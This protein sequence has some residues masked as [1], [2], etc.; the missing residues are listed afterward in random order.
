MNRLKSYF[1]EAEEP[2]EPSTAE[3]YYLVE[4]SQYWFAVSSE[5][6]QWIERQL[7]R[8][9]GPR[10]LAFT[11]LWGARRRV[12]RSDVD[13]ISESTPAVRAA[14]RAFRRARKLEEKADRRPWEDDD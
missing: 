11:D 3:S 14:G 13:Y 12:R 2:E 5:T 7:G 10:W 8:W 6:A 1:E 9:W 4:T